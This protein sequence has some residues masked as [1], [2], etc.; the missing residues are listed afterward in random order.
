[1]RLRPSKEMGRTDTTDETEG[2][3]QGAE[4]LRDKNHLRDKMRDG[5]PHVQ[6]AYHIMNGNP[7]HRGGGLPT[8][9]E[10]TGDRPP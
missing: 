1:M 10:N 7:S 9:G 8:G 2:V 6:H 3:D 5:Q 4:M